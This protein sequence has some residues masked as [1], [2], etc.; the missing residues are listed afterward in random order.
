[1]ATDRNGRPLGNYP[2]EG[3]GGRLVGPTVFGTAAYA[4]DGQ[5]RIALLGADGELSVPPRDA[6]IADRF[7]HGEV[8]LSLGEYVLYVADESGPWRAL[9][10]P[11]REAVAEHTDPGDVVATADPDRGEIAGLVTGLSTADSWERRVELAGELRQ[12]LLDAPLAAA[13]G[14]GTLL[15]LLDDVTG[16]RERI[17]AEADDPVGDQPF[18]ERERSFPRIAARRELAQGVARVVRELHAAPDADLEESPVRRVAF[19]AGDRPIHDP[20]TAYK[21]Y[22]IDALETVGRR[23]PSVLRGALLELFEGTARERRRGANAA[24]QLA[25]R[26]TVDDDGDD[27]RLFDE[28]L[29]AAVRELTEDPDPTVAEAA[30]EL[31]LMVEFTD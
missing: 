11:A 15:D 27:D 28:R 23:R 12:A 8:G 18:A 20:E 24:Y 14:L 6:R 16:E 26:R 5:V 30:T 4:G 13:P 31:E 3:A 25:G 17:P 29:R 9:T 21:E 7:P 22:L 2:E 1:M 19:L 10:A